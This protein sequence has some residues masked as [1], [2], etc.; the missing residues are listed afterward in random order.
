MVNG[1][2]VFFPNIFVQQ[3]YFYKVYF[4]FQTAMESRMESQKWIPRCE[5]KKMAYLGYELV[6]HFIPLPDYCFVS[7][8]QT[9]SECFL[10]QYF[11]KKKT[12]FELLPVKIWLFYFDI[13]KV[14]L[15]MDSTMEKI[16]I[17]RSW[18][19][20]SNNPSIQIQH[21]I[22]RHNLGNWTDVVRSQA[23]QDSSLNEKKRPFVDLFP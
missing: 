6:P 12:I 22:Q 15:T 17:F 5:P 23:N 4:V 20:F 2:D 16:P 7:L 1:R 21:A 9:E 11:Q 8:F 14:I 19:I 18:T 13:L 3:L 10:N